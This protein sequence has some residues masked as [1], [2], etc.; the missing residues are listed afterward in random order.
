V[1]LSFS[2]FMVLM[3][4]AALYSLWMLCI[5]AFCYIN[6]LCYTLPW[7]GYCVSS[8]L[9]DFARM[10]AWVD[11]LCTEYLSQP[12]LF[13]V[14]KTSGN[15]TDLFVSIS[16]VNLIFEC[17]F[18]DA[19]ETC[20]APLFHVARLQMHHP[21]VCTSYWIFHVSFTQSVDWRFVGSFL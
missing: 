8:A 10:Y 2:F 20:V 7:H 14:T 17:M 19:N 3:K 18:Y 1:V 9:K 5:N 21:H 13:L 15:A 6:I 4:A 16:I 12:S 11:F